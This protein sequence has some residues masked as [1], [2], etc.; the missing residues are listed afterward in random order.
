MR[1]IEKGTPESSFNAD[2]SAKVKKPV[3]S[4]KTVEKTKHDY[5]AQQE[6]G[7][8]GILHCIPLEYSPADSLDAAQKYAVKFMFE[9]SK[10]ETTTV[11]AAIKGGLC[12][13]FDNR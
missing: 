10:K 12:Q 3:H 11:P 4:V 5:R 8:A 9:S 7:A 13:W 6:A 2:G 1:H